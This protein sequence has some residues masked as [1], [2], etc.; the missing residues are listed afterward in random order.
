MADVLQTNV[1]TGSHRWEGWLKS[2]SHMWADLLRHSSDLDTDA[3]DSLPLI[4]THFNCKCIESSASLPKRNHWSSS[5]KHFLCISKRLHFCK[6]LFLREHTP[7]RPAMFG[8]HAAWMSVWMP[9]RPARSCW[10]GTAWLS[11]ALCRRRR[12]HAA[13]MWQ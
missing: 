9:E 10:L 7:S 5:T 3:W 2:P 4:P 13:S 12:G 1:T 6:Y 8:R 11:G